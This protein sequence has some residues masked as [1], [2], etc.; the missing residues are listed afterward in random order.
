MKLLIFS[1]TNSIKDLGKPQPIKRLLPEWYKRAEAH[2]IDKRNGEQAPGLKAC[3]PY[4]DVM[5]SGYAVVTPFDIYVSKSES[6]EL[7]IGWN[8][9]QD[10]SS[11]VGERP[12]ELGY[13]MP[14][15]AGH[16]PNHLSW[17]GEWGWK[18]PRGWSILL[19]HPYNRFDLPFTTTSGLIDSDKFW[20]NGNIPFFLKEDFV[21][22][23]PAGTPIA[24]L[25]PVKRAAWKAIYDQS[26]LD[27][28]V[29]Q[30]E[31]ARIKETSYKRKSWVRKEY[32]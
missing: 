30:G 13:T 11:F 23:I 4:M 20:A 26:K 32:N 27:E 12:M 10:S 19:T 31:A 22:T 14:R 21:G 15:P 18:A 5:I 29:R 2:F 17:K 16:L 24:Q 6:G 9:P 3:V 1:N 8:G 28:Y 7:K 25:I